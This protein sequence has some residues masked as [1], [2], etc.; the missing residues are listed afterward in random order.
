MLDR[1][2]AG[3]ARERR[4]VS[5]ASHELRTP[6]TTMRAELE[7]ALRG[8]RDAGELRAAIASAH[9]ETR[10]MS[11]LADDLLVLARADQGRL[12]LRP[13]PPAQDCSRPRPGAARPRSRGRQ[14][15]R[16]ADGGAGPPLSWPT[17]IAWPRL[18][19]T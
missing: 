9:E 6:L 18:S 13:E 12:P 5:D 15:D 19:T 4:L 2:E 8:E 11:R 17:P 7:L 1:L 14:L 3:L 16:R 10:R